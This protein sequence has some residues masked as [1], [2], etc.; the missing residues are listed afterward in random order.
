MDSNQGKKGRCVL[1]NGLRMHE[2]DFS[3]IILFLDLDKINL[4]GYYL[5]F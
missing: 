1:V 4:S 5:L 2:G 3:G